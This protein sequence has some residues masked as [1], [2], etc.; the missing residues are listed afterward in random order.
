MKVVLDFR[1]SIEKNAGDYFDKSKKAKKKLEGALRTKEKYEHELDKLVRNQE[2]IESNRVEKVDRKKH[3]FEKFRWFFTSKG[4]LV[5][6]GRDATTNEIVIKKYTDPHD[7]VFHTDMAGSPFFVLKTEGK[8][9]D[10]DTLKEVADATCTFSK[11]WKLGI[12]SQDVFYVSPSQVTKEAQSGEYLT[13]GS[14]MIRGKTNYIDNKIDL[15]IGVN[16]EGAVMGGPERSVKAHCKKYVA[17]I[18]GE[19]KASKVAKVI[20][21]KLKLSDVDEIIRAM[22]SGGFKLVK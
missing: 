10:E 1:K 19:E 2:I 7:L 15:C 18:Q 17:L 6:G 3:W 14:F 11:A 4:F 9:V 5:I 20:A 22:S 12:Q 21:H 8:D 13:K 16:E